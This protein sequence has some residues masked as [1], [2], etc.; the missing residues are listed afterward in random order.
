MESQHLFIVETENRRITAQAGFIVHDGV[1]A[2][3][4]D[5]KKFVYVFDGDDAEFIGGEI[6]AV[7][8]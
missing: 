5:I 6:K 2:K 4:F 3:F 7:K 8:N 1:K